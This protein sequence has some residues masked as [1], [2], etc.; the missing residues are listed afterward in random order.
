MLKL[1]V[2]ECARVHTTR[3][4]SINLPLMRV[5]DMYIKVEIGTII[6][7]KFVI[8][9]LN[10]SLQYCHKKNGH[11]SPALP[12]KHAV[13]CQYRAWNRPM[14]QASTQYRPGTGN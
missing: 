2:S 13:L 14:L 6:C 7:V 5:Y 11:F 12:H 9:Q 3:F 1:H 8:V 4:I 10:V